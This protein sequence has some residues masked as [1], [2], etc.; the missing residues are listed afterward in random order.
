MEWCQHFKA[1]ASAS[2]LP[3]STDQVG[4]ASSMFS[5]NYN[6]KLRSIAKSTQASRREESSQCH[7]ALDI[8][9]PDSASSRF[10]P[11]FVMEPYRGRSAAAASD[12]LRLKG[13]RTCLPVLMR[14]S[15]I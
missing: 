8:P 15:K 13:G 10:H 6:A 7:L 3:Y 5:I 12:R 14:H 9:L 1:R 4:I 11:A 2:L